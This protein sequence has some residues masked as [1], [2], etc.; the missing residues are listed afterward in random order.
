MLTLTGAA[1]RNSLTPAALRQHSGFLSKPGRI[2][3]HT[4]QQLIEPHC[5]TAR[6]GRTHTFDERLQLRGF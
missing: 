3:L 6:K 1:A 4:V 5:E 2:E